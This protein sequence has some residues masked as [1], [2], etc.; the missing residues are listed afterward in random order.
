MVNDAMLCWSRSVAVN[1]FEYPS[2]VCCMYLGWMYPMV[3][4]RFWWLTCWSDEEALVYGVS[5]PMVCGRT[6]FSFGIQYPVSVSWLCYCGAFWSRTIFWFFFFVLFILG[7]LCVWRLTI[8]FL[9][10]WWSNKNKFPKSLQ[11]SIFYILWRYWLVIVF[12]LFCVFLSLTIS[13]LFILK[14]TLINTYWKER[15]NVMF[16]YVVEFD[17]SIQFLNNKYML[18]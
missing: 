15:R 10:T 17:K 5:M 2:R 7:W 4:R 6:T 3:M 9:Q 11:R 18:L 16:I 1:W 8:K 14:T 13:K 12:C